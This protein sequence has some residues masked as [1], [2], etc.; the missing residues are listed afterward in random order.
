MDDATRSR[1]FEPFFTTK[2]LGQGTGLGLATVYGIVKQ[3]EGH[4]VV[5][6]AVGK[7]TTFAIYFPVETQAP[8]AERH[9][10]G[11][12]DLPRGT[13]TVLVVE[14]EDA[15]RLYTREVLRTCGYTVL[16]ARLGPE[17]IELLAGR[18]DPVDLLVT[19]LVMPRMH[20]STLAQLLIARQPGLRVLFV[21][22]YPGPFP[23]V[24]GQPELD[25]AVLQKPF[26][27]LAL[28]RKVREVLDG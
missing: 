22:G 11:W 4:I 17:A 9:L 27:P 24:P 19:D 1:I 18:A 21:T 20:G 14:D 7:G 25:P 26:T 10:V 28:A 2:E 13:E 12:T 3:S 5:S 6:S 15:V 16:E 23:P 8:P